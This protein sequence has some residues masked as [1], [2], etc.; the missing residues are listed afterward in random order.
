MRGAAEDYLQ[1]ALSIKAGRRAEKTLLLA[2]RIAGP[3]YLSIKA[4]AGLVVATS[5]S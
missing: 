1:N 5:C 3:I 2:M 4:A